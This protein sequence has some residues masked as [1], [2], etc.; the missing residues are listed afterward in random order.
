LHNQV[1]T[2]ESHKRNGEK[3]QDIPGI[4]NTS[5]NI[6][7]VIIRT[8]KLHRPDKCIREKEQDE[9]YEQCHR[10]T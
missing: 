8:E 2:I 9:V 3:V 10:E 1:R 5:G 7:E 6:L 4:D